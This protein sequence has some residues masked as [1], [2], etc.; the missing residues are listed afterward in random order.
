[1]DAIVIKKILPHLMGLLLPCLT[2][3]GQTA[4]AMPTLQLKKQTHDS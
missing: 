3:F 2:I 4:R 1:M